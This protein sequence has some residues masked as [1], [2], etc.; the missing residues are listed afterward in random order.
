MHGHHT[1][2]G[3]FGKTSFGYYSL[4]RSKGARRV[5][6]RKR[7][8]QAEK[9][10]QEAAEAAD[11][12]QDRETAEAVVA[13]V[14]AARRK[15]EWLS[16]PG[17]N[18]IALCALVL[19][20]TVAIINVYYAVRGPEVVVQP[21]D[22][23]LLY[24]DGDLAEDPAQPDSAVLSVAV[25]LVMINAASAEHGDV[26]TEAT[27]RMAADG[28]RYPYQTL[29]LPIFTEDAPAAREKCEVGMR[30]ITF[31]DLVLVERSD[32]II[33][34]PGGSAKSR[35]LSFPLLPF[36]C[37][38]PAGPCKRYPHFREAVKAIDGKPASIQLEVDF[39]SDGRRVL[40]CEVTR[41]DLSYLKDNGWTALPCA[42]STVDDDR[43]F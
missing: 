41:A 3:R 4:A 5:L 38:G 43:W 42:S 34:I 39:H 17:E 35:Y 19:S 13:A 33:D 26:M 21:M 23:V 10:A 18:V 27:L 14:D 30:C 37:K 9:A 22:S 2:L 32:E 36:T 8:T 40:T 24:R 16:V 25:P 28:G 11:A 20:L 12:V 31:D 1:K 6:A 7:P 15:R 29:V